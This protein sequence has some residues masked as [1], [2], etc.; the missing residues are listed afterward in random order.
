MWRLYNNRWVRARARSIERVDC[1]DLL[2]AADVLARGARARRPLLP[3]LPGAGDRGRSG[4]A[5]STC[6]LRFG[7]GILRGEV[8]DV[9]RHGIWSFHHDDERVIRGGPPSFWEV[10]DGLATT[11]VLLQR[12]TD[13]LDAGIPLARATFRT[14]GYSYPRNRDRAALGAAALP[15]KVARAVRDGSLDTGALPAAD[16]SAPIRRDPAN[17][18]MLRFL[19]R[20]A[21]RAV[22]RSGARRRR[23]ARS[24]ASR[25]RRMPAP[26]VGERSRRRRVAARARCGLLRRPVPGRSATASPP[27]SWRTSTSGRARAA[28]R[29]WSA[30]ATAG[31]TR[32]S[33]GHRPRRP[34]VVPVSR[35]GR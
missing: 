23:R 24:G 21:V 10:D 6:M 12:L 4:R 1:A 7:F 16:A 31:W 20:Q 11:G 25:S 13:Q 9:A 29:R 27:C 5:G 3:A 22:S 30:V 8:L 33:G 18:Q 15:A 19:A 2:A 32:H 28:S 34:R 35:R 17:R 14:V 26:G